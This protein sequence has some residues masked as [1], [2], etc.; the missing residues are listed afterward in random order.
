MS[1][2]RIATCS[3]NRRSADRRSPCRAL[4]HRGFC[5]ARGRPA[6]PLQKCDGS[7]LHRSER[8]R[9]R[10]KSKRIRLVGRRIPCHA[11]AIFE[12][13]QIALSKRHRVGVGCRALNIERDRGGRRVRFRPPTS[14]ASSRPAVRSAGQ[15]EVAVARVRG[16]PPSS[17]CQTSPPTPL[18]RSASP[19]REDRCFASARQRARPRG[20]PI[21]T[22]SQP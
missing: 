17:A 7:S 2:R 5:G 10:V 13:R 19:A 9:V 15:F 6:E 3:R 22:P 1:S 12:G 11:L 8:H 4:A 21:A 14:P 20:R 18:C 16:W